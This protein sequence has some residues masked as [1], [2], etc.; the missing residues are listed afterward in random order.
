MAKRKAFEDLEPEWRALIGEAF[1][2]ALGSMAVGKVTFAPFVIEVEEGARRM[3]RIQAG[4]GETAFE[5]AVEFIE[6]LEGAPDLVAL[7]YPDRVNLMDGSFDAVV[8]NVYPDEAE[9][10]LSY[11]QLFKAEEGG[12]VRLKKV[13]CLGEVRNVLVF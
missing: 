1:D 10:G 9:S 6:E 11:A 5:T 3:T 12:V 4:D 8:V 2:T 7:A 13:M